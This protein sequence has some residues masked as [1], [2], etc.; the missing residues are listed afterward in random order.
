MPVKE[1]LLSL[2]DKTTK[3]K[4]ITFLK[5][6]NR[7]R[8]LSPAEIKKFRWERLKEVMEFAYKR[9]ELYNNIFKEHG[10]TPKDIKYEEDLKLLP[11]ITRD[12]IKKY[13]KQMITGERDFFIQS[14]GTQSN[15]PLRTYLDS[16][17]A[18]KKYAVYL[19]HLLNCGWD[20]STRIIFFLPSM[21]KNKIFDY[22][23]GAKQLFFT[24]IQNKIAHEFFTNREVAFYDNLNPYIKNEELKKY[25]D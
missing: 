7:T 4:T 21:Y 8:N 3:Y 9:S 20:F 13:N 18:S 14:S 12:Q 15:S 25:W 17:A 23:N 16:D 6:L 24:Y 1:L 11:L 2:L 5:E 22:E 19:R 10:L